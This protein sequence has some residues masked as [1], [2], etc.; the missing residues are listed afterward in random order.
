MG[1][2]N[3]MLMVTTLSSH[4]RGDVQIHAVKLF[5]LWLLISYTCEYWIEHITTQ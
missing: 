2:A 1:G 5:E 4:K 3:Q